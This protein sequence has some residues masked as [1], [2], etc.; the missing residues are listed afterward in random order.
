MAISRSFNGAR[1]VVSAITADGPRTIG[2]F[3]SFSYS[4][5]YDVQAVEILGRYTAAELVYT[6]AMPITA[7]ASGYRV[8][9]DG[10]HVNPSVPRV[11]DLLDHDDI[12]LEVRDRA[13]GRV[14]AR[15]RNVRPSGYDVNTAARQLSTMSTSY[16]GILIDEDEVESSEPTG[17]IPPPEL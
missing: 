13:T 7:N 10:A 9:D 15:I 8:I 14:V 17:A 6:G 3:M 5:A 12:E 2:V 16:I 4:V 11:Q 1:A